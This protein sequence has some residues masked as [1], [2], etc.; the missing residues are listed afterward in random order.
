MDRYWLLTWSTYGSRLPG[1]GRG[2][3]SYV[4]DGVDRHVIHNIPGTPFDERKSALA[5][6]AERVMK[7]DPVRLLLDQALSLLEQFR[8]TANHRGWTL[9][10]V[11]IMAN[12]VHL[13]VGVPG[14]PSP[15]S[16]LRDFKAYGSRQLNRSWTKPKSDT[17]W[18]ESGSKRK[19]QPPHAVLAGIRY[20]IEQEF[21]LVIWT[22]PIPELNVLGGFIVPAQLRDQRDT[23]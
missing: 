15:A 3:V 22:V 9:F 13:V 2:F 4:R 20:V 6:Y 23:G 7:G 8:E 18:T 14:D 11:G 10:A 16:I 19:L 21:P 12:H 1:D 5:H 17:W